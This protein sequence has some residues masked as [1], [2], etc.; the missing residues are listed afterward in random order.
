MDIIVNEFGAFIGKK[1]ERLRITVKGETVGEHPLLEVDHLLVTGGGISLSADAIKECCQRGIPID[2][3][4]G[5]GEVYATV[6]SP[7]LVGTIMT[8][9]EQLLAYGDRRS[10]SLGKAFAVGKLTNQANLLR[11]MAKYRRKVDSELYERVREISWDIDRQMEKVK[12]LEGERIDDIRNQLMAVEGHAASLYWEALKLL[13]LAEVEWEG[14]E[15]R[16]ATDLVNS[17]LNYGYGIL[18]T[19]IHRALILAGLDPYAGFIHADRAG[20]LS[21][22]YD[23]VEEFRPPVVD[24]TVF[25]LLNKGVELAVE[26]GRLTDA[27]RKTLATKVLERLDGEETYEGKKHKLRIIIYAQARRVTGHVRGERTYKPFITKW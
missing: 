8:R 5:V 23:L 11:Y 20:K 16:G 10:V 24:R 12:M 17:L 3:L 18:Y 1:S 2:F 19:Q 27:T 4:S 22:V 25:A 15:H 14:R 26:D 21:L 13:L 6:I 9:R 7:Q